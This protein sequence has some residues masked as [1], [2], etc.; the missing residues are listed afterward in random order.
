RRMSRMSKLD[1][2]RRRLLQVAGVGVAGLS[3]LAVGN[4]GWPETGAPERAAGLSPPLRAL[5]RQKPWFNTGPLQ[6][7][8]LPGQVVPVNFWT[9]SC[10]N[11]L[12]ALPYLCE[13]ARKYKD[14]GLVVIGPHTPEFS[15]EHDVERVRC[16]IAAQ[17]VEFP[18]VIDND[19][20][21]WNAFENQAWPGFF[22]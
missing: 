10:S 6:P 16:A 13:W 21:I 19:Y 1:D 17:R 7:T 5:L 14:R 3:G 22:F 2:K 20:D 12:R 18:V 9:Y 8:D 11:S 4:L 15:F